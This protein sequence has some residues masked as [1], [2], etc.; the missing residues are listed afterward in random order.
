M[1][2]D[3]NEFPSYNDPLPL[4]PQDRE[5]LYSSTTL[6][7]SALNPLTFST[8]PPPVVGWYKA[9]ASFMA[10]MY[11]LCI[12]AGIMMLKYAG[13][14][15]ANSTDK[16]FLEIKIQALGLIIVG[17]VLFIAYVVA[18]I[19]PKTSGAWVYHIVMIA[20]GL[21]S[22]C[23]WPVTIPLI[24][25]WLKPQTQHFFGRYD[26]FTSPPRDPNQ[27]PPPIPSA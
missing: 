8:D 12:V 2:N 7:S 13:F 22:C 11:F 9:Y 23:L 21:T 25:A 10:V 20:I 27:P 3:P 14:I 18:L 17:I 1:N 4:T 16:T 5:R 19:L 26:P 6:P 15:L 24:I